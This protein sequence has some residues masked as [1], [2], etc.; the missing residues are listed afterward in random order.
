LFRDNQ[1]DLTPAQSYIIDKQAREQRNGHKASTIWFTGLSGSG[2]STLADLLEQYLFEKGIQVFVLDGDNIRNGINKD[3]DFS[4]AGRRENIRRIAEVAKLFCDAGFIVITAFISPYEQDREMAKD[5]I[6][7]G[8]MVEVFLDVPVETCMQRDVKG[9]YAKAKA[10]EIKNFTGIDDVYEKPGNPGI[11]LQT[12][13]ETPAQSLDK[14]I[15][16]LKDHQL[17][18]S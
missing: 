13:M 5:I 18:S 11:L 16:W 3:L 7:A 6:G 10:G 2:K 15:S 14:I 1:Q 8:S 17:I 12:G 4:K 9:M